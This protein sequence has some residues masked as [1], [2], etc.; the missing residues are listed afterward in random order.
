M[1]FVTYAALILLSAAGYASGAALRAGKKHVEPGLLDLIGQALVWTG[2]VVSRNVWG[3]NR[4]LAIPAWLAAGMACGVMISRPRK[5]GRRIPGQD[6]QV[7]TRSKQP[8]GRAWAGWKRFARK[9]GNFQSRMF[10]SWVYF[11]LISPFALARMAFSDPLKI[12]KKKEI[13]HWVPRKKISSDLEA[14]R[15]QF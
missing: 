7:E 12:K 11:L 2:A 4:W 10:L 6:A 1:E 3:W 9:M 14:A 15:R 8:L 5:T 13:S